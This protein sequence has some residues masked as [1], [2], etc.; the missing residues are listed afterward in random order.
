MKHVEKV[1]DEL[2]AREVK[3]E[4]TAYMRLN[5]ITREMAAK[6]QQMVHAQ[7]KN[8]NGSA[9]S[10]ADSRE[11]Y[12]VEAYKKKS[13]VYGPWRRSRPKGHGTG[14]QDRGWE[15]FSR[16]RLKW[17]RTRWWTGAHGFP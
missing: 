15:P 14:R 8:R 3:I 6:I 12:V 9:F 7:G 4:W 10:C 16:W 5:Y 2:I 1:L 13:E 11:A 17:G